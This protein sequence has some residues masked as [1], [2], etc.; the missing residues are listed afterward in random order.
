VV[1]GRKALKASPKRVVW[2][3]I[4][5]VFLILAALVSYSTLPAYGENLGSWTSTINYGPTANHSC[6]VSGGYIYCVGG[7]TSGG[8]VGFASLSSSGIGT[9]T[10]PAT[11]Y[12]NS[13]FGHSCVV[14]GGY[15]YCVGGFSH[16]LGDVFTDLVYFASLLSPG[17]GTWT[18]TTNYPIGIAHHSCVASGGYIYCVAGTDGSNDHDDVYFASLSSSGVGTWTPTTTYPAGVAGL[19][20]VVSGDYI[21]CVGGDTASGV[22]NVVY[23]ASLSSS[24]VGTWTSTTNYPINIF[25]HSCVASGGY[26]YCVAGKINDPLPFTHAAYF[27]FTSCILDA[28]GNANACFNPSA[29]TISSLS[30]VAVAGISPSPPSGV[31]FPDEL[32]SFS[33][34]GLSNGQTVVVTLTLS[35][36]LPAGAFSYYKFQSGAWTQLPGASLDST[37]T[38]IT[39]TLTDGGPE[40]ADGS[41]NGVIVDPGGPGV[42]FDF[43][44]SNSGGVTVVAGGSGSSTITLTLTG[45]TAVPVSL[46]ASGFPSGASGGFVVSSVTPTDASML[47]VTTSPSTP[48]GAYT[49]TVTGSGG[50]QTHTTTFT[51]QVNAPAIVPEYPL[52]LPLLAIFMIFAYGLIRRRT[53]NE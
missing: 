40:D 8:A 4:A 7:V 47:T 43:S 10:F 12:P 19:S 23:F 27:S 15:I 38:V 45:G 41:A 32:F 31:T 52:G 37:R 29:G 51:L 39:L 26:I 42:A 3:N 24:G 14:S 30:A 33:V 22:T 35:Q 17:V 2:V 53:Q 16:S 20:C 13:V 21:Y 6:V 18:P 48:V 5:L 36:P 11:G 44:I 28:P 25:N 50:G 49:I 46:S 1:D 9:W 34:S